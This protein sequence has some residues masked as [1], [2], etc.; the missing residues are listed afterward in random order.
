MAGTFSAPKF[1]EQ[2]GFLVDVH[3]SELKTVQEHAKRVRSLMKGT[4]NDSREEWEQEL[5]K[6]ELATKRAQSAVNQ[7][8]KDKVDQEALSKLEKEEHEKRKKGKKGWWM[9]KC[10]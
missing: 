10:P 2:Y 6:L 4:P 3:E 8:R 7:D 9:K 5:A 1:R